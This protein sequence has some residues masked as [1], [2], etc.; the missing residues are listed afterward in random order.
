LNDSMS[1]RSRKPGLLTSTPP[2]V[3]ARPCARRDCRT[4]SDDSEAL[5]ASAM[6]YVSRTQLN[7]RDTTIPAIA[8]TGCL[9]SPS[10]TTGSRWDGQFTQASFTRCPAWSTIHR[11]DVDSVT[12][13]ARS[14]CPAARRTRTSRR[15]RAARRDPGLMA[16]DPCR[17]ISVLLLCDGPWG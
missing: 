3:S 11:D 2:A 8:P 14:R 6:G 7:P 9:P 1:V 5:V 10:V 13:A 15:R 17:E 4:V 12:A 16:P